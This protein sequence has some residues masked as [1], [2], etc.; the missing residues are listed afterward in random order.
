MS[1]AMKKISSLV[2][3]APVEMNFLSLVFG[4]HKE[5]ALKGAPVILYGAGSL[6]REMHLALKYAGVAPIRFCDGDASKAGCLYDGLPVISIDELKSSYRD[7]LVVLAVHKPIDAVTERLVSSGIAKER[8]FGKR[9]D[10]GEMLNFLHMYVMSCTQNNF[11]DIWRYCLPLSPLDY[12][13]ANEQKVLD[14]CNS[15]ADDKSKGLFIAKLAFYSSKGNVSLFKDF[16]TR[17]SEPVLEFGVECFDVPSEERYYFDND[18]I[19]LKDGEVYVDVGAA[20]GDTIEPFVKACARRGLSYEHIHAFEPDPKCYGDL[21]R[22]TGHLK[23]VSCHKLGLW[24]AGKTFKFLSTEKAWDNEAGVICDVG[25]IEI[26]V[27]SLDEF[28]NSGKVTFLKADLA[29]NLIPDVLKGAS[30]IIAKH[31]PTLILGVYHSLEA[32]LEI[33]LLV[34]RICPSYELRLRHNTRH[35]CDTDMFAISK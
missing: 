26:Q 5:A 21:L 13:K 22:K 19:T 24:S 14:V 25:D 16:M 4:A 7:A 12:L 34:K 10:L 9:Q 3:A 32:F 2:E 8:L 17:F 31:K 35:L 1:E 23:G 27:V 11:G 20:D 30:A 15:F 33:P 28:L 6:G 29:G 18:M